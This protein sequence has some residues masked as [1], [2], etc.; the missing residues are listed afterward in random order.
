MRIVPLPAEVETLLP[1]LGIDSDDVTRVEP[2]TGGLSGGRV[3]R[4]SLRHPDGGKEQTRVLK[5]SEPL[6]GWLGE[7]SGDTLIR[8]AQ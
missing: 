5:Y 2:L 8:E 3:Y 4:L 6:E 1:Q 7:V